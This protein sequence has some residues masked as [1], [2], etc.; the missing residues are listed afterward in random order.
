MSRAGGFSLIPKRILVPI[1]FSPSSDAALRHAS[2]LAEPLHSEIHL[3]HVIPMFTAMK[4]P[5]FVPE[6]EFIGAAQRE[7]EQYFTSR[8]EELLGKGI[9]VSFSVETSNDVPGS[10]LEVV[11]REH[12]DLVVISTHGMTGWHPLVFG[13]TAEKLV[14]LVHIPVL[15][16]R[17]AQPEAS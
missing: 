15:L 10:I 1:D 5:D 9:K 4:M 11:D 7:A 3:V 16:L 8:Q 17:T 6:T 14:K 2:T 12:I 13:S